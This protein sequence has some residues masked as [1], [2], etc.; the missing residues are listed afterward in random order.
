[1]SLTN[2]AQKIFDL[3]KELTAVELAELV[4]ALEEEFGVTA[5]VVAGGAAGGD[6]S[7]AGGKDTVN[8]E[9]ADAG[10]QKIAV[11]KVVKELLNIDLKAAKDL[12]EKA[13]VMIKEN[14]KQEEGE[15]LQNKLQEAGAT[16]NLK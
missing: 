3:V 13:P 15:T 8:V 9:L 4:K 14:V 5:M 6:D 2:N 10:Q 11:I 7:A 1:M 12:V 16:V